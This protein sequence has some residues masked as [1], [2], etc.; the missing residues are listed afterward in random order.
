MRKLL[1]VSILSSAAV[2][3]NIAGCP[4]TSLTDTIDDVVT[5]I[6]DLTTTEVDSLQAAIFAAQ[7]LNI[8][9]APTFAGA[10]AATGDTALDINTDTG[11]IT[12]GE[13]PEATFSSG[14]TT[15][16]FAMSLD[17][18]DG[19]N[20]VDDENAPT[21][22]GTVT[23][24]ATPAQNTIDATFEDF[25]CDD[26]GVDGTV[27]VEYALSTGI[28]VLNG[29]W[30]VT[31]NAAG[32]QVYTTDGNGE[33]QIDAVDRSVVIPTFA[34][35]VG[36]GTSEWNMSFAELG[37]DYATYGNFVPYAGW[38]QIFSDTTRDVTVRF[39]ESSPS[40]GVV[41]ISVEGSE[42]FEVDLNDL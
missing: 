2:A 23:G 5:G 40:T 17:F 1:A 27:S 10:A 14:E 4:Q 9:G 37:I 21:C 19:C 16:T 13:C 38:I 28:S 25:N 34:A 3:L 26:Y 32:D 7:S 11:T 24:S 42:F 41:E 22:V 18:G 29:E 36:D 15:G 6:T 33:V 20:N 35:T 8:S 30:D 31:I 39:N 12:V